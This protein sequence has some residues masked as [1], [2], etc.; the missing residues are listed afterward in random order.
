G[1]VAEDDELVGIE[2]A[3]VEDFHRDVCLGPS[4]PHERI[5]PEYPRDGARSVT[6]LATAGLLVN[7]L[8]HYPTNSE[9]FS[10]I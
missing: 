2:L 5:P 10:A 9:L 3:Q 6:K 8:P 7:Y 4:G 1:V